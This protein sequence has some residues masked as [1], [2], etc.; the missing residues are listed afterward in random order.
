MD[1]RQLFMSAQFF[2]NPWPD[3]DSNNLKKVYECTACAKSVL[4][5]QVESIAVGG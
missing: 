3:A 2:N 1:G 5:T 4:N